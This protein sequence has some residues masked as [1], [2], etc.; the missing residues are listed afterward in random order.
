MQ[1]YD[2]NEDEVTQQDQQMD[3]DRPDDE[4]LDIADDAAAQADTMDEGDYKRGKRFKK[5]YAVLSSPAVRE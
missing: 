2:L 5:L 3:Q 4:P 1:A